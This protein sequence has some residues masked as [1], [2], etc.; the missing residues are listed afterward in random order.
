MNHLVQRWVLPVL[1]ITVGIA[2]RL[3][4]STL[5]WTQ[6]LDY[7]NQALRLYHSGGLAAVATGPWVSTGLFP[8]YIM[9]GLSM[10]PWSFGVT[11]AVFLTLVD[12]GLAALVYRAGGTVAAALVWLSP[13]AIV[14]SG[15]QRVS[16]NGAIAIGLA[17]VLLCEQSPLGSAI[18]MGLSLMWKPN[19][20]LF[21]LWLLV[22]SGRWTWHRL[23]LCMVP[24]VMLAVSLVLYEPALFGRLAAYRST[25]N[26]PFWTMFNLGDVI[27]YVA[28]I[29]LFGGAMLLAGVWYRRRRP[30]ELLAVYTICLVAFSAALANHYLVIPLAGLA[31][32]WNRWAA[33][34]VLLGGFFELSSPEGLHLSWM[35]W[36]SVAGDRELA[37]PV[38]RAL[39]VLLLLHLAT[40]H[41]IEGSRPYCGGSSPLP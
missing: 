18:L 31:L 40:R 30:V 4:V 25:D 10:L 28:P 36:F 22:R 16:D 14:V 24:Y 12:L 21:P 41:P 13:I 39:V 17:S 11:S 7:A 37:M 3:Y 29:H 20:L 15:Y 33:A 26:A 23:G 38:Y 9:L 27:A 35:Q 8:L 6:D 19:L 1:V 34:Y 2:A 5:G 32:G